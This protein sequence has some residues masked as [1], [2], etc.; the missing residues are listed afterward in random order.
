METLDW[1]ENW[2][3]FV[4]CDLEIWRMTL[5]NNRIPPLCHIK[6][7]ASYMSNWYY[8]LDTAKLNFYL[9][10]LDLWPSVFASLLS[11]VII[12]E[13]SWW[14][15]VRNIVKRCDRW[16]DR[17]T[18][19]LVDCLVAAEDPN[20]SFTSVGNWQYWDCKLQKWRPFSPVKF[21]TTAAWA[22]IWLVWWQSLLISVG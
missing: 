14:C 19:P 1:G 16:I 22:K 21:M 18:E 6:L 5:K 4:V 15:D 12:P 3:F 10:D 13:N 2:Q 17:R 20:W 9:C 11:M 7:C 8:S